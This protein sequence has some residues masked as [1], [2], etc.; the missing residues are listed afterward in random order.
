MAKKRFRLDEILLVLMV[1]FIGIAVAIYS[2]ENK[3]RDMGAEEITSLLSDNDNAS[4]INDGVINEGKLKELQ[5]MGYS[6]L[7]DSLNVRGDFCVYIEDEK[8]QVV[9]AKGS[10]KL[11]GRGVYCRE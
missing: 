2:K 8:G 9:L 4:L 7:K 11:N 5:N 3:S 10:P 6:E 1:A